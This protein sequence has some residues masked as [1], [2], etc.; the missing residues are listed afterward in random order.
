PRRRNG[1][2]TPQANVTIDTGSGLGDITFTAADTT[3]RGIDSQATEHND[4]LLSAG[5][6][7][8]LSN[9]DLGAHQ[10]LGSLIVE[11]AAGGVAFGAADTASIGSAGPVTT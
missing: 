10:T 4:L 9:G 5:T 3:T 11:T 8:V 2:V 6:G 7:S 1:A